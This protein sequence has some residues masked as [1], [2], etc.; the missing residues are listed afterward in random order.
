MKK[1]K[2]ERIKKNTKWMPKKVLL[3]MYLQ[4]NDERKNQ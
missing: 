4:I 1:K 2:S 3:K